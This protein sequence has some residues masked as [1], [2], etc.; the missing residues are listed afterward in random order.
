MY[1]GFR[2]ISFNWLFLKGQTTQD[3]FLKIRI[4][5]NKPLESLSSFSKTYALLCSDIWMRSRAVRAKTGVDSDRLQLPWTILKGLS[6]SGESKLDWKVKL[7][8]E[9]PLSLTSKAVFG[10]A[11]IGRLSCDT[12]F[13]KHKNTWPYWGRF[14]TYVKMHSR[15][16]SPA[17]WCIKYCSATPGFSVPYQPDHSFCHAKQSMPSAQSVPNNTDLNTLIL[18]NP[19]ALPQTN[20]V[21]L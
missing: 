18:Q 19:T 16:S 14:S 12:Q 7:G 10:S 20:V 5:K 6:D 4:T 1:Q 15:I 13:V 3:K 17:L 8:I 21:I 2:K 11:A 9:N